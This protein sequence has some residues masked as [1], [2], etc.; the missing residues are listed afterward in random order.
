MSDKDNPDRANQDTISVWN[1]A[2]FRLEDHLNRFDRN[3]RKLRL[4]C[5]YS[6]NEQVAILTECVR[7]THF[8][9]AF[10]LDLEAIVDFGLAGLNI[11]K[12][13]STAELTQVDEIIPWF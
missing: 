12:F 7:R 8:C 1:G 5:S 10:V 11:Q 6:C 3:I 9:D 2:F 4:E 13:S